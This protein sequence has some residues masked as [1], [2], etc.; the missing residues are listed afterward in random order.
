MFGYIWSHVFHIP[1]VVVRC[2]VA[3]MVE[4]TLH[5]LKL[6]ICSSEK[7]DGSPTQSLTCIESFLGMWDLPQSMSGHIN[8]ELAYALQRGACRKR[9]RSVTR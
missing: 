3:E 2:L 9:K 6:T 7:R 4:R 8:I 5:R 1:K